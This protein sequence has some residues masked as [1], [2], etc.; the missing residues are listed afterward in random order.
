MTQRV[1][2]R[3]EIL[4]PFNFRRA[5]KVAGELVEDT[6]QICPYS[7]VTRGNIEVEFKVI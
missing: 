3:Q 4:D 5:I 6:H 2:K 1:I 7:K